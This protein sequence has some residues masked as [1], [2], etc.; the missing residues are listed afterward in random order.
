MIASNYNVIVLELTSATKRQK[1]PQTKGGRGQRPALGSL[2]KENHLQVLL[3]GRFLMR[4]RKLFKGEN[5]SKR[6]GKNTAK[7]LKYYT[8]CWMLLHLLLV[9]HY[10][11]KAKRVEKPCISVF[12]SL[13]YY[14]VPC[15]FHLCMYVTLLTSFFYFSTESSRVKKTPRM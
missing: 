10:K 2:W 5:K 6:K 13:A 4:G 3:N 8:T 9:Y 1:K 7:P 12:Y 14:S 15:L 11:S